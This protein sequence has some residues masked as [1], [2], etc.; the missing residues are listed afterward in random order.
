MFTISRSVARVILSDSTGELIYWPRVWA[1]SQFDQLDRETEWR[2]EFLRIFGRDVP[3]PRLTAWYGDAGAV[4]R[5]SGILN[6]PLPWTIR[7]RQLKKVAEQVAQNPFNAVLLNRYANGQQ[8]QG[9]HADDEAELGEEPVIASASFGGTRRFLVKEKA[10]SRRFSLD[11]EDG[12]L[13]IMRGALQ[14]YFVHAIGK[15][16]K[17]VTPRINLTFR[18]IIGR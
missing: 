10:G 4:Y 11:L 5:Y 12:S 18:F 6:Q 13:L 7:L 3:L 14:K 1:D 16:A 9:Y 15:T 8:H 17:D 2:Q